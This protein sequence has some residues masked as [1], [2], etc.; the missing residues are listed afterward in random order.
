[1]FRKSIRFMNHDPP[2]IRHPIAVLFRPR[3]V[4]TPHQYFSEP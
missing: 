2:G 1:L 3:L 4:V